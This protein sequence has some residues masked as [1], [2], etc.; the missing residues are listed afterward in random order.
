A[1]DLGWKLQIPNLWAE[2]EMIAGFPEPSRSYAC[3]S[4]HAS[5]RS[6]WWKVHG[7]VASAPAVGCSHQPPVQM[8]SS[9]PSPFTSP[10]PR[11]CENRCVPGTS[12]PGRLASL[13]GCISQSCVGSL[14][15]RNHAICPWLP[16]VSTVNLR[17]SILLAGSLI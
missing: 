6:A 15:G 4:A 1:L 10:T 2:E 16:V 12:W 5:P 17:D 14:P 13:I 11:P 8:T 7:P 3:M 9:R